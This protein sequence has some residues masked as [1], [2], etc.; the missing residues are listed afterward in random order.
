[1]T[2]YCQNVVLNWLN[3]LTLTFRSIHKL[4]NYRLSEYFPSRFLTLVTSENYKLFTNDGK[5]Y[6]K[7]LLYENGCTTFWDTLDS[8]SSD[9]VFEKIINNI[10]RLN[11][12]S[13]EEVTNNFESEVSV[14]ILSQ[15]LLI[16]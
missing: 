7:E 10:I 5:K 15:R 4:E 3:K 9:K 13:S 8:I 2:R 12:L 14:S 6:S 1:M 16:I 11:N